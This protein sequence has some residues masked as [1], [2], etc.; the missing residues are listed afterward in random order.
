MV[1]T[2]PVVPSLCQIGSVIY[3]ASTLFETIT[4]LLHTQGFLSCP[5]VY[6]TVCFFFNSP[7]SLFSPFLVTFDFDLIARKCRNK[8]IR[9]SCVPFGWH[10]QKDTN[11]SG[12]LFHRFLFFSVRFLFTSPSFEKIKLFWKGK[13]IEKREGGRMSVY[14]LGLSLSSRVRRKSGSNEPFQITDFRWS[15]RHGHSQ[16]KDFLLN[17]STCCLLYLSLF[18]PLHFALDKR[19]PYQKDIYLTVITQTDRGQQNAVRAFQFIL[20]LNSLSFSF[21]F[22]QKKEPSLNSLSLFLYFAM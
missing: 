14:P 18:V 4:I 17:H 12:N 11:H 13:N 22:F 15:A 20:F 19:Q 5:F 2:P 7:H 6:F 16:R 21:S 10:S 9:T 3:F 1:N 8:C